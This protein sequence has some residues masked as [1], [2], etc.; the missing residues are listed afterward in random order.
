MSS[1]AAKQVEV[2]ADL[3]TKAE[4]IDS[5]IRCKNLQQAKGVV[6]GLLS[7]L[8]KESSL[9]FSDCSEPVGKIMEQLHGGP[10]YLTELV[11]KVS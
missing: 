8:D 2:Q 4:F 6:G 5:C 1:L 11:S 3:P 7:Q 9:K 10:R